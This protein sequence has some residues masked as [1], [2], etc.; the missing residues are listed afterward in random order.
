MAI[1]MKDIARDLQ[2]SVVTVSKV[3]RNHGGISPATRKRVLQRMKE[4]NYQPNWAARSLATKR[5]YTIGLVIPDLM[6][7]FFAEVAKGVTRKVRPH[8]Y[9]VVISNSEEDPEIE[10]QEVELLLARQVDGL[11]LASAQ[12]PG[13]S[14]IF[15]RIRQRR[16]PFVLIDRRVR[17]LKANYVGVNDEETGRVATE[18]LIDRGCQR[19][20]HIRGPAV[21][22]GE[23]RLGG[24][25][26]AIESRR[27]QMP[28]GYVVKGGY[29]VTTGYEAMRR[30][31]AIE[32]RPDGVFCFND[33][34]AAGAVKAILEAGLRVPED[35][36]VVG[37]GN[38]HY[39]DLLRVPLST[40]D[41]GSSALGES[42]AELLLQV[43]ESKR[44]H[45]S[46][47]VFLPPR[48]IV[49]E[50]SDGTGR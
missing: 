35:I 33:P 10:N 36:A 7:S 3:F 14:E 32:P 42:A 43:I 37:A 40:I 18:H 23:G 50:S 38:V 2:V 21:S 49:R 28:A 31:L 22:T 45:P 24:Y 30:L 16:V 46:R 12:P 11:I 26:A 4:L 1:R 9:H 6:H 5:T 19:I 13:R 47:S 27:L 41:Q 44:V 48:L 34:V 29:G 15:R 8:G 39:S 20:A 25:Q 17:G